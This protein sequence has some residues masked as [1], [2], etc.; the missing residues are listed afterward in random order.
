MEFLR[1]RP[2]PYTPL[3]DLAFVV[4]FGLIIGSFL[5]V[6]ILRLP[7]GIS[8]SV[9]R[10]HCPQCKRL[11]PWYDNIPI[12]SYLILRGH[13]RRCGKSISLR[14]PLI[15]GLTGLVSLLLYFKFGLSVQ[16]GI[17]LAFSAALIALAFIDLD[18]RI[19]PD[20][21]T[22]NGIWL[23]IVVSVVLA[24]PSQFAYRL[25]RLTGIELTNTRA[26]AFIGSILG[27]I[28][29]GGLL[30]GV[31]EAYLRLRGIE[32]MGLGDVKMMAMV[33]AFLGA[34]LAL[35]TIMVGSLLGSVLGLLFIRFAGKTREYELPFGTFLAAAG[36]IAVLYGEDVIRWYIDQ[37]IRPTV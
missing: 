14:Y 20:P 27:A 16:W 7:Q 11:I 24:Q 3:M 1:T 36:I 6:V 31:A 34:P 28:V 32:G 15:E 5:N 35:L 25:L 37:M 8:I 2:T 4:V 29:G 26:L 23:G 22:L 19:L 33:G 9:P 17:F 30:W 21:I 10:S 12:L 13:C 18:H